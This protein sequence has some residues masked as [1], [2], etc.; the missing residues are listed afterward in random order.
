M[1]CLSPWMLVGALTCTQVVAADV[2]CLVEPK[3]TIDIRAPVEGMIEAIHVD[4]GDRVKVGQKLVELSAGVERAALELTRFQA[5]TQ[6]AIM[7]ARSRVEFAQRKVERAE[8]MSGNVISKADQD[9]ARTEQKVAEADLQKA[10]DEQR[11][12]ALEAERAEQIWRLKTIVSPI[13][14]VVVERLRHRGEVTEGPQD[15]KPILQLVQVDP[16][17][18]EAVLPA[19]ALGQV[20]EQDAV[21]IVLRDQ[22]HTTLRA[23]VLVVDQLVHSA[24]ETFRVRMV[25]PN[26]NYK[27]PAGLRCT[28]R[29]EGVTAEPDAQ[30]QQDHTGM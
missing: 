23:Q 26:E 14:G 16:L 30:G 28:A 1:K 18:V 13:D 25:L 24:S 12:A 17:Y 10:K 2:D 15:Q 11:I 19:A 27:I 5:Q 9:E 8:A 21:E 3:Q 7:A 29:F 4:R 20:H 22:Q 6:G